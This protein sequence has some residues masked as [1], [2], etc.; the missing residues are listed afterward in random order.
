VAR[1]WAQNQ[2]WARPVKA[3]RAE[4]EVAHSKV[5][6]AERVVDM[7]ADVRAIVVVG[8]AWVRCKAAAD[9]QEKFAEDS[10]TAAPIGVVAAKLRVDLV[11]SLGAVGIG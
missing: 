5:A 9:I 8:T 2:E 3:S 6:E 1:C 4:Q 7:A 10:Q 11:Y